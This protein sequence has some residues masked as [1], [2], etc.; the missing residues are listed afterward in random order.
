MYCACSTQPSTHTY[1]QKSSTVSNLEIRRR[2]AC[3]VLL[4]SFLKNQRAHLKKVRLLTPFNHLSDM[5]KPQDGFNSLHKIK[6][7]KRLTF[8]L[9][10]FVMDA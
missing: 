2:L 6:K 3:H 1:A 10:C 8:Y 9:T 4:L 5:A 7:N